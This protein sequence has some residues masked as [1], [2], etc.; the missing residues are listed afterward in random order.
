MT[1][2]KA[3]KELLRLCKKGIRWYDQ[4]HG[5]GHFEFQLDWK[6][7]DR[8]FSVMKILDGKAKATVMKKLGTGNIWFGKH[9]EEKIGY[10]RVA[11]SDKSGKLKRLKIS[12]LGAWKRV[13]LWAEVLS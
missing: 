5:H 3:A 2:D 8:M 12:N 4:G 9:D 7:F 6:G 13:R 1:K 11:L 10:Y